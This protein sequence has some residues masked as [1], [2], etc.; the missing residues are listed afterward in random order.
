V[1]FIENSD[2]TMPDGIYYSVRVKVGGLYSIKY[3]GEAI[4]DY[5]A[6]I[7]ATGFKQDHLVMAL[8]DTLEVFIKDELELN[9]FT[10]TCVADVVENEGKRYSYDKDRYETFDKYNV[11]ISKS[12]GIVFYHLSFDLSQ[13]WG[14]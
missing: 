2:F 5:R 3:Q 8:K 7:V 12:P 13:W 11:F 14:N 6:K 9:K 4:E 1:G 10:E